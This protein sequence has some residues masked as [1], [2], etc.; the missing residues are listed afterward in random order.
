[1]SN[2][3]TLLF[4]AIMILLAGACAGT[5]EEAS[6]T[7]S[8]ATTTQE[9]TPKTEAATTT[10]STVRA[11]FPIKIAH[12]HGS[13]LIAEPPE[14]VVTV[15][16]TDHDAFLALGVVP[17][18]TTEW[19]G[20]HPGAIWPWAVDELGGATP[21]EIVGTAA[22]LDFE[23]IAA[24]DPDVIVGLYASIDEATYGTLSQIAPTVAPPADHPDWTIP[25]QELTRT[26]GRILGEEPAA[27]RLVS[28]VEERFAA[29][30]ADH[31]ELEA[32]SSS[33]AVPFEGIYVYS[34]EVANGRILASLGLTQPAELAELIGDSDG[35]SLS[36]ER[37]DL[38]DLDVLVWLDAQPGEGILAE[39]LYTRLPVHTEGREVIISSSSELGGAMSFS[40]VLSLPDLLNDLVPMLSLAVDGDPATEVPTP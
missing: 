40:S 15:G 14:R 11:S 29:E 34:F 23:R 22:E 27:E 4:V 31:P 13:T 20:G 9:T 5:G 21:P 30:R 12:Q 16:L 38:L 26:V 18:G 10:A 7:T 35:A 1:M 25:W 17:V 39:P 19:Y 32:A 36:L 24:L 2:D 33:I 3:R 37:V 6:T 8:Q 28:E